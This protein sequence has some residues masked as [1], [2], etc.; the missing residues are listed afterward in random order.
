MPDLR[1]TKQLPIRYSAEDLR[2]AKRAAKRES[3]RL[4]RVVT[5]TEILRD[6]GN[7]HV[8]HILANEEKAAA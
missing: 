7:L 5:H 1:K 3:Q 6:G 8:D 4:G 2:R